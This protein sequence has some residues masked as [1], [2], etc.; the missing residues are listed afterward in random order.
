MADNDIF[1]LRVGADATNS[2][3]VEIATADDGTEPIYIRQYTEIGR[4]HV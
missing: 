3:W 4:A 2:G 1:R